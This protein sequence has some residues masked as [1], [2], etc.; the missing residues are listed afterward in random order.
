VLCAWTAAGATLILLDYLRQQRR[1]AQETADQIM[2]E[3][4]PGPPAED[5]TVMLPEPAA[6]VN[7]DFVLG[8]QLPET[9]EPE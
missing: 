5:P 8:A 4:A 1:L 7:Q 2:T 6:P 9:R 3:D